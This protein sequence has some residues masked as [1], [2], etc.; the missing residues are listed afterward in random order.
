MNQ[1]NELQKELNHL[2]KR[3]G[4]L[5]N[6]HKIGRQKPSY[7]STKNDYNLTLKEK[8]ELAQEIRKLDPGHLQRI[9]MIIKKSH[10][11]SNHSNAISSQVF[12][13]N[14]NS[15]DNELEEIFGVDLEKLDQKTLKQLNNYIKLQKNNA[16]YE[17]D[18]SIEDSRDAKFIS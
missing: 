8:K 4:E 15:E 1:F 6:S 9:Y 11:N 7:F 12:D 10:L 17:I 16:N 13:E 5:C 18:L 3:T 14:K 2:L